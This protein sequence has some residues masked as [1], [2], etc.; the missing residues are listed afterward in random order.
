ML[1]YLISRF[2][3]III[4]PEGLYGRCHIL[5]HVDK[6][7]RFGRGYPGK[8]QPAGFNAHMFHKIFK[9]SEFSP[10]IIITFQVMAFA[11]MSPG[12]PDSV[13]PLCQGRKKKLGTHAT[14]ARNPYDPYIRGIFHSSDTCKVCGA[15][16]APVA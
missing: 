3:K 1:S 11:G 10:R 8:T 14:G 6:L 13:R 5:D 12:D 2:F 4:G 7:G 15:V 9:K 16:A